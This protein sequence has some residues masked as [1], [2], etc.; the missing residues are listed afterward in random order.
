MTLFDI[1]NVNKKTRSE[2]VR[3]FFQVMEVYG[4]NTQIHIKPEVSDLQHLLDPEGKVEVDNL[5]VLRM[6]SLDQMTQVTFTIHKTIQ[7]FA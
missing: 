1:I 2:E 6:K 4:Q 5:K 3:N 7:N